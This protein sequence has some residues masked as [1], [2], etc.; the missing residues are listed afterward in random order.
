MNIILIFYIPR[1][2]HKD[3]Y[4][5]FIKETTIKRW[6]VHTCL[7]YNIVGDVYLVSV[8]TFGVMYDYTFLNL[9]IT[10]S[11]IRPH[12]KWGVSLVTA[13]DYFNLPQG[14]VGYVWANI[15]TLSPLRVCN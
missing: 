9:Q 13:Y 4:F 11:D 15:L 12:V 3:R 14:F 10:R 5:E 1:K 7:T 8:R 6:S 2:V